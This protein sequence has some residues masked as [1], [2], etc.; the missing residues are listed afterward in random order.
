MD[1]EQELLRFS[2]LLDA[3]EE[4]AFERCDIQVRGEAGPPPRGFAVRLQPGPMSAGVELALSLNGGSLTKW[5]AAGLEHTGA[6]RRVRL[7]LR[8]AFQW[9]NLII[10]AARPLADALL[11]WMVDQLLAQPS[12]RV[13][14]GTL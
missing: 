14:V 13:L 11:Q 9:E 6:N 7:D 2:E 10:P 12:T 4:I 5:R 1:R 3:F 8:T